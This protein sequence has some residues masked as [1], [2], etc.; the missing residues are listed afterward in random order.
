MRRASSARF[1][2]AL[3]F[4]IG[5]IWATASGCAT[6]STVERRRDGEVFE[7]RVISSS[8][9]AWFA[10]GVR[11]EKE[12]RLADA[13]TSYEETLARDPASGAAWAALARLD[14]TER[15]TIADDT[16]ERGLERADERLPLLLERS[17]CELRRGEPEKA[18]LSAD[19]AVRLV[20]SEE[21]ATNAAVAARLAQGKVEEARALRVA[22]EL[23][24]DGSVRTPLELLLPS[25]SLEEK[26]QRARADADLATASL[27]AIRASAAG[28][29]SPGQIALRLSAL[30]RHAE[31]LEQARF[32]LRLDPSDAD[33]QLVLLITPT[34]ADTSAG[35][36]REKPDELGV[37]SP[38]ERSPLAWLLV[39]RHL[40]RTIA[41][42]VGREFVQ[43]Q[44][45][46]EFT[47]PLTERLRL[48]L[49]RR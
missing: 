36:P 25:P 1:E 40:A 45:W 48:D 38:S 23:F 26:E 39:G 6:S 18:R 20:P 3:P 28:F 29:Y 16:F 5:A 35:A 4:V 46:P 47:D 21:D 49:L 30:D 8:A 27:D 41:P 19:A 7:S 32:V 14:C 11:L 37:K 34:I 24:E 10:Q 22:F 44:G 2:R 33:A 42:S 15:R 17:R 13:R 12:G 9:Y 43:A 31:A